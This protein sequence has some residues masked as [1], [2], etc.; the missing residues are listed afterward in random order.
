[1]SQEQNYDNLS[2]DEL[3]KMARDTS[4][5]WISRLRAALRREN[6]NYSNYDIREIV[7]KNCIDMGYNNRCF[8]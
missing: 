7:K 1:M 3:L 2:Y 4:K 5:I 8:T 6:P